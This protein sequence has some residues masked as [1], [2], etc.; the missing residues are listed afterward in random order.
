MFFGMIKVL[1]LIGG[2]LVQGNTQNIRTI[3]GTNS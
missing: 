2:N 3:I 1:R